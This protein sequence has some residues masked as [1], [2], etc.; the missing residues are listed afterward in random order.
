MQQQQR[1]LSLPAALVAAAKKGK[2]YFAGTNQDCDI[3]EE[4]AFREKS[5]YLAQR[6]ACM[7]KDTIP[8]E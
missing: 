2:I 1:K 6:A 4:L 3:E 5:P 7:R 8:R